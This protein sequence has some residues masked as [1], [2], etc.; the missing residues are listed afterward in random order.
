MGDFL[1]WLEDIINTIAV[2]IFFLLPFWVPI[3]IPFIFFI[4]N[5]VRFLKTPEDDTK[6]RKKLRK[7]F[8]IPLILTI[9]FAVMFIILLISFITNDVDNM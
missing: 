2:S 5:L 4:V 8:I 9:I 7:A 6:R 3:V 1:T